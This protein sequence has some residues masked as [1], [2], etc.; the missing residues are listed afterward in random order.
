MFSGIERE[1]VGME[2][3]EDEVGPL[4][5]ALFRLSSKLR[6]NTSSCWFRKY[7]EMPLTVRSVENNL[8]TAVLP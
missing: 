6:T 7:A 8:N 2:T 1:T 4:Q 3:L 5:L